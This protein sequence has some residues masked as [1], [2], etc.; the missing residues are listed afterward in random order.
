MATT[1]LIAS[2]APD[3]Q[4]LK[5]WLEV[6]IYICGI[7]ATTAIA[8]RYL[9]GSA[10]RTELTN[11]TVKVQAH[12]DAVTQ[13]QLLETHGRISRERKE[14]DARAHKLEQEMKD[15]GGKLDDQTKEINE[16]I[17]SIPQKTI[18]LLKTVKEYH[19]G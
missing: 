15:L 19:R 17:D 8:W 13:Q 7:I 3:A 14:I 6:L 1:H 18:E 2:S 12:T 16:R 10:S 9:T 11:R 4:F 5:D